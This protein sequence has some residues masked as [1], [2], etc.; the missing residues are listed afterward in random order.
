MRKSAIIACLTLMLAA[1]GG[2]SAQL[3]TNGGTTGGS[4]SSSSSG[5]SSSSSSGGGI[6]P[7]TLNIAASTLNIPDDGSAS[8]TI[9]AIADTSTNVAL[10]G[11]NVT[12][13]ASTGGNLAIVNNITNSSGQA[14]ATVTAV[15]SPAAG[16]TITVT[17]TAGTLA[18]KT[19]TLNVVSNTTVPTTVQMGNG[20]VTPF[21]SGAIYISAPIPTGGTLPTVSAGGSTTLQVN[22]VDQNGAAWTQA[23]TVTFSSPCQGKNLA[24]ITGGNSAAG[25]PTTTTSS[26][27][28]TATYVAT[29]CSGSDKITAT[30]NS[31]GQNLSAVGTVSVQASTL[32]SIQFVSAAPTNITLKGLGSV[33][34]SS[35]STVIFQVLDSVGG[36]LQGATVNFSLS[37]L[38][39]G[40]SLTPS[41]GPTDANGKVQT[42]VS[43]GTVAEP[44]T[45][46]ASTLNAATGATITT[47]S[48]SL[49]ISTGI[50]TSAGISL[51]V[52]CQNVE[53]WN[54]DG[55][56]VPVTVRMRDRFSNPVPDGTTVN[57]H[58]LLGHIDSSCQTSTPAGVAT[59]GSCSVNW[60]SQAPYSVAGNPQT[61]FNA[62]YNNGSTAVPDF[63]PHYADYCG[64][65]L[66]T[67]APYNFPAN[68]Y[69]T[70]TL[71][72]ICNT[73][74][75]G[76]SP[77]L[78]YA[79]GEES[80]VDT[81]NDGVF[82]STLDTVPWNSGNPWNNFGSYTD[83]WG[84][85]ATSGIAGY[86][87]PSGAAKP[88]QDVGDP[89][90][91]QWELYTCY[92]SNTVC[93][94]IYVLGEFFY[95]FF[96]HGTW[97]PPDQLIEAALCD[98]D[99]SPTPAVSY[100]NT[101]NSTVGIGA[102]NVIILSGSAANFTWSNPSSSPL[103]LPGS[104]DL[105]ISD[106][107]YQQMPAGTS[108]QFAIVPSSAGSITS[109]AS[110]TWPCSTAVGG[111][112]FGISMIPQ[113]SGATA[114][115]LNVTVTTP[116]GIVSTTS[117]P[118]AN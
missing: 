106:D 100:C 111:V 27:T 71:L 58:T 50:P 22:L 30:A 44:V 80:F 21:Q 55:V 78:A 17:A 29:G 67:A 48:N 75:N 101:A 53:A 45:V 43:S 10:S 1:C 2:G 15:G 3:A 9:T 62:S 42:V 47:E 102:S 20:S 66:P 37:T 68:T 54:I 11:V 104:V 34:G 7:A 28:A 38:V 90:L 91:N 32:G 93:D 16:S 79:V 14:V 33:G 116:G 117:Y 112:A 83:P 65:L 18:P 40:V 36:P 115:S 89:F 96:N 85:D 59:T 46:K 61:T 64:T 118:L 97:A 81:V 6:T 105:Q 109:Q 84:E 5:G 72:P 88:W 107:H 8:V 24:K 70:A 82:N 23:T 12:F 92:V 13:S 19:V 26:G 74:T 31:N 60:V 87:Q 63:Y 49:T 103:T 56:T 39:G 113:T 114:G 110:F 86:Q 69:G 108:V 4:S 41:S 95:D 73:T 51:A 57:F 77:I 25:A 94:P 35:T 98:A 99:T 76:R 52:K